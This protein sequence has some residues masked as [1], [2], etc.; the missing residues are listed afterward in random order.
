MNGPIRCFLCLHLNTGTFL[1]ICSVIFCSYFPTQS[2]VQ[3]THFHQTSDSFMTQSWQNCASCWHN[4]IFTSVLISH[5]LTMVHK[6]PLLSHPYRNDNYWQIS[7]YFCFCS[8]ASI[9][10]THQMHDFPIWAHQLS[11]ALAHMKWQFCLIMPHVKCN[12][13]PSS[14]HW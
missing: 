12:D 8:S 2:P 9:S 10:G 4:H 3:S 6:N 1:E 7:I 13:S 11:L 14:F 5:C